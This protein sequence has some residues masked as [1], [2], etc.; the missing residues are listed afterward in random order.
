MEFFLCLLQVLV[1]FALFMVAFG[2]SFYILLA[3]HVSNSSLTCY[4]LFSTS[5]IPFSIQINICLLQR[6]LNGQ[7]VVTLKPS[8]ASQSGPV[9]TRDEQSPGYLSH[10]SLGIQG[11][12]LFSNILTEFLLHF[13]SFPDEDIFH[14]SGRAQ[15]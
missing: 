1:L 4:C 11:A 14:D 3:G 13:A 9:G 5:F 12:K 6:S 10:G 8:R 2:V 15:L 7:V